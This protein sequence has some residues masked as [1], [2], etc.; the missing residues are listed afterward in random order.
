MSCVVAPI[1][2]LSMK[3]TGM[4]EKEREAKY[5][6]INIETQNHTSYLTGAKDLQTKLLD[7]TA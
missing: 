1:C 2:L 3:R 7:F 6:L 5:V 4:K